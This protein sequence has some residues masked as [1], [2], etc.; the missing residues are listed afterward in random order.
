MTQTQP[1]PFP[2]SFLSREGSA[3]LMLCLSVT[4]TT[5]LWLQSRNDLASHLAD[6]FVHRATKER[7]ILISRLDAY[8]QVLRGGQALFA[9]SG[10]VTREEWRTYVQTLQ[11]ERVLPGIQGTGFAQVIHASEKQAHEREMR[12]NGFPDYSIHPAGERDLYIGIVFI[13]PFADRNLRA[14]GYDMYSEPV[15]RDAMRRARDTGEPALS[16]KVTLVQE[17]GNDVQPGF[18]IYLPIFRNGVRHDTPEERRAALVGYVYSPF[19]AH[20]LM[21]AI[22]GRDNEDI[23]VELFEERASP[24]N[25]LFASDDAN[26][27]ARH[28]EDLNIEFGG[29]LW[30]ARFKSSATFEAMTSSNEPLLI[31]LGGLSLDL[32]LFAVMFGGARHR[33]ALE[34]AALQIQHSRDRF[35]ALVENVPGTVFRTEAG[36]AM[37]AVHVSKGIE[38]LTGIAPERIISGELN[39]RALVH[40]DD[41]QR[42]HDAI[43]EALAARATY[44]IEYRTRAA[45]GQIRWA[46]ERGCVSCDGNGQ[47]QWIDGVIIDITDRKLAELAIREMAFYDPLTSLPNRRLLLDRLQQQLSASARTGMHGALIFI[48]LDEFKKINDTLGHGTGDRLLIEVAQRLRAGVREADTVA[49][50]GGDEFIVMLDDLGRGTDEATTKAAAIGMKLRESLQRPYKLDAHRVS[51]TPSMGLTTFSGHE[52]SADE[53]IRRADKAMYRAKSGGHNQLQV[54]DERGA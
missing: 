42:V 30:I 18:L 10:S 28:V 47:P 54:F 37:R 41:R 21:H 6:R 46:S 11:L 9:A 15:R 4:L 12:S 38:A 2:V 39:C 3:W 8:E 27:T 53:L 36:P 35:H 1:P 23:E 22:L 34:A 7:S 14:F 44:N 16:G 5:L 20:D 50:L 32:L 19:R 29:R 25:L 24:E 40:P 43:D 33:R 26:R 52:V 48:D 13:E 17:S 45:D 49:R 31:L 51:C